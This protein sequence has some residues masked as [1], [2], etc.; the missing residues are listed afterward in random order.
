MLEEPLLGGQG[1]KAGF[2][3]EDSSS[4]I[5]LLL[6]LLL[7]LLLAQ[8]EEQGTDGAGRL[9]ALCPPHHHLGLAMGCAAALGLVPAGLSLDD[10]AAVLKGASWGKRAHLVVDLL[11]SALRHM[12]DQDGLPGVGPGSPGGHCR[13]GPVAT[14]HRQPLRTAEET[15]LAQL[16]EC[17]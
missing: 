3:V 17:S 4:S 6:L 12:M 8:P 15:G 5:A 7:L 2:T 14:L 1:Q 9:A 16:E 11:P 13:A 10:V